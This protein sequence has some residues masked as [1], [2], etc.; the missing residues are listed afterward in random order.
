MD[1]HAFRWARS[2]LALALSIGETLGVVERAAFLAA[3][4]AVLIGALRPLGAREARETVMDAPGSRPLAHRVPPSR[5]HGRFTRRGIFAGVG[6]QPGER[7]VRGWYP[8]A[9]VFTLST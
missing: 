3:V 6:R 4:A 8:T 7:G 5:S 2:P 1:D 9:Y